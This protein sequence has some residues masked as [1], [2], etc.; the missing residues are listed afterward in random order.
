MCRSIMTLYHCDPPATDEEIR[1]AALQYVRKI[2][3]FRVPAQSNEEAFQAAVDAVAAATG[4]LLAHLETKAPL[5]KRVVHQ[6]HHDHQRQPA[7]TPQHS[8]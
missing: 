4:A 1:A 6:H 8:V 2:S 3:G 5:R 7:P